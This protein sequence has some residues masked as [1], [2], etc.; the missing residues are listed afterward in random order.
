VDKP[1]GI[2]WIPS[3]W[4]S[5]SPDRKSVAL[6]TYYVNSSSL[7][8]REHPRP[9]AR[10]LT[11]LTFNAPVEM[12][13]VGTSGWAQVRDLKTSVVGWAPPRNLSRTSLS[14]PSSSPRRRAPARKAPP[15]EEP[16]PVKP[17]GM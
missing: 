1:A 17:S 4:L 16:A 12:L 9:E 6:P 10:V 2:G 15:K 8:L 5:F 7:P 3:D 13:G 14:S 11:T